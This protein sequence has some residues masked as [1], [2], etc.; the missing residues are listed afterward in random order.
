M[1]GQPCR[2]SLISVY[3][4]ASRGPGVGKMVAVVVNGDLGQRLLGSPVNI[5]ARCGAL[6]LTVSR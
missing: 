6:V 5:E 4:R 3:E 1:L 2:G